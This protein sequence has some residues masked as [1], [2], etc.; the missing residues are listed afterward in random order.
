MNEFNEDDE[1]EELIIM[2]FENS[3][4]MWAISKI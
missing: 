3:E 1:D 2:L 4:M